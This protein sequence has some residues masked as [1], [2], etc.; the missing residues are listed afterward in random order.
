MWHAAWGSRGVGIATSRTPALVL[1]VETTGVRRWPDDG[2]PNVDPSAAVVVSELPVV[3]AKLSEL[4]EAKHP[5]RGK[6]VSTI[7]FSQSVDS[8]RLSLSSG[9]GDSTHPALSGGQYG[10]PVLRND[11]INACTAPPVAGHLG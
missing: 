10:S 3:L 1:G 11:S 8:H 2:P 6:F 4:A 9:L 7:A 5:S